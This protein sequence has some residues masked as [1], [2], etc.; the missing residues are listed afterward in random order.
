MRLLR[1]YRQYPWRFDVLCIALI[2]I[3]LINVLQACWVYQ[4]FNELTGSADVVV[5]AKVI[6]VYDDSTAQYALLKPSE[7]LKGELSTDGFLKLPV[8]KRPT[9]GMVAST[10]M[11][12]LYD[13]ASTYLLLLV[14]TDY[15]Y[16]VIH[17]P[18]KTKIKLVD[19][20]KS[21]V[22]DTKR[23]ISIDT[24]SV[25]DSRAEQYTQLL[26]SPYNIIRE[27]AAYELG[28][29]ESRVA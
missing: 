15:G 20:N 17:Y 3:I 24:V 4:P 12:I 8:H 5:V 23:M 9:S 27:S 29:T 26:E 16:D 18:N 1:V 28:N 19:S 22:V 7:I 14:S 11:D 13:S 6:K 21:L 2:W 10:D 25:L